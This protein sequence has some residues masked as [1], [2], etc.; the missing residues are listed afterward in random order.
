[1]LAK[2]PQAVLTRIAFPTTP[3]LGPEPAIAAII[4]S[5][6]KALLTQQFNPS[7]VK[8]IGVSCGGPLDPV[9]GLIQEPPNLPGWKDIPITS[10]LEKEFGVPCYLENDANAGALA[11][12]KFGAGQGTRNLIFLTMG[13]GLGAGLIL[14]GSL[15]RGTTFLAGEVGHVRLTE[16]GPVGFNK[17]GSVEGWASGGGMA[18]LAREAV[19]AAKRAG[20]QTLLANIEQAEISARD[21][22]HVAQQG[23]EV[24]CNIVATAGNKL[25]HAAA[26]L[27]DL[28]NPEMIAIGGLALRMGDA[29]LE[30]ARAI[31]RAEAIPAAAEACRIVPA[32]LGEQ[33]GDVAALCIAM[34]G[35]ANGK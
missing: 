7:D 11:E 29:V 16:T 8:A 13:T 9:K 15:Y 26:I 30:P 23:D 12:H 21:V 4:V 14:N 34:E 33:I 27:V 2:D 5:I 22:W 6:R 10:I 31:V 3:K 1:V 17:A 24:A 19:A 18:I 32:A 28:F 35:L 20:R 25:G